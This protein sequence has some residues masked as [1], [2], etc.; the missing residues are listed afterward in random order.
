MLTTAIGNVSGTI[1][2]T[3]STSSIVRGFISGSFGL[4]RR[5]SFP[6]LTVGKHE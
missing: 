5:F 4:V 3:G 6:S 1:G 2:K